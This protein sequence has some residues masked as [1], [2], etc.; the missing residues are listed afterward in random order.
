MQSQPLVNDL[1]L[2]VAKRQISR[3]ARQQRASTNGSNYWA[4]VFARNANDANRPTARGRSN[5]C[6]RV[7]VTN[8]HEI[9]ILKGQGRKLKEP[10][11]GSFLFELGQVELRRHTHPGID[12]PLLRNRQDVV[13]DPVQHQTRRKE[14]EHHAENQRHKPH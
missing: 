14:E 9:E 7:M 1:P 11:S 5:R 12:H 13:G 6:D 3:L 4:D 10:L 2:R 8:Q